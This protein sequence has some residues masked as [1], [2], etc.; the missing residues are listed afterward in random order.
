MP[1]CCT[2]SGGS[3][4]ARRQAEA[5]IALCTEQGFAH[6][7]GAAMI[8]RGWALAEGGDRT[9]GL[10][11]MRE[12]LA[13]KR[14]TGAEINVPYYLGLIAEAEGKARRA[15]EG[16]GVVAEALARVGSTGNR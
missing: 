15:A 8:S 11:R 10:A 1:P 12:G 16:R 13:A 2:S 7:L 4:W 9:V 6:V 14:A 3:I 5:A